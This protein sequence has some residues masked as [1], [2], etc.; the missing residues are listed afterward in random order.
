ML[1]RLRARIWSRVTATPFL[2]N[3]ASSR[4]WTIVSAMPSSPALA[5]A[6]GLPRK[7]M[8]PVKGAE[9]A[10][11]KPAGIGSFAKSL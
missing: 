7:R 1:S 10:Q 3:T 11:K 2:L 9:P 8:R 4:R 6:I 5:V